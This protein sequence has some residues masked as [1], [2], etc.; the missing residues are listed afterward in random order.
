MGE[1]IYFVIGGED[2]RME[3]IAALLLI[4]GCSGSLQDCKELPAPTTIFETYEE[5]QAELPIELASYAGSRDKVLGK[6]VYVDPAMEEE[7]A[8]L[9]WDINPDGTLF[10]EIEAVPPDV[11]SV[12]RSTTASVRR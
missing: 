8:E 11:A 4:V 9:V 3:H 5:C 12:D 10:A 1:P 7:D 6:C 2:F